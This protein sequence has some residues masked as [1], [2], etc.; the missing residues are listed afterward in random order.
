MTTNSINS[1]WDRKKK[2]FG[3]LFSEEPLSEEQL[4]RKFGKRE[5]EVIRKF[6]IREKVPRDMKASLGRVQ[7]RL[8]AK[9]SCEMETG[10]DD[11]VKA[12]AAAVAA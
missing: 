2:T 5:E 11:C 1:F 10:V 12:V 8:L 7:I 3:A 6:L 9:T 4:V